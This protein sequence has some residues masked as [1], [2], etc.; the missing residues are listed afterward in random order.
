M[1][2]LLSFHALYPKKNFQGRINK[3]IHI[4]NFL[5]QFASQEICSAYFLDSKNRFFFLIHFVFLI[6]ALFCDTFLRIYAL[7][8]LQR[9]KHIALIQ[10]L[11]GL[12][13][14]YN[15]S[16]KCICLLFISFIPS[17]FL[18]LVKMD[19][20]RAFCFS[21]EIREVYKLLNSNLI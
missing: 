18:N 3:F 15:K 11:N 10:Q 21:I 16:L 4:R 14:W 6:G 9:P 17:M 5:I 20:K 8:D 13:K 7:L 1:L 12:N 19:F 2:N